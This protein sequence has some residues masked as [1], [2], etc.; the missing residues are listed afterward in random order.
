MWRSNIPKWRAT[1]LASSI[2]SMRHG[3]PRWRRDTAAP[4]T[5]PLNNA[6]I[7]GFTYQ[8]VS[9]FFTMD[10]RATWKVNG[11][12]DRSRRHR[13]PKQLQVLELPP[14]PAAHALLPASLRA[15]RCTDASQCLAGRINNAG[16][17]AVA[18]G[19]ETPAHAPR[20]PALPAPRY[21]A[22]HSRRCQQTRRRP[23]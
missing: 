5:V 9:R 20:Y 8:G 3:Q 14:V 18:N 10:A 17:Y 16:R 2:A 21:A 4:S 15:N 6:D 7:N 12:A 19:G 11:T 13:Q 23:G 1:A 22:D